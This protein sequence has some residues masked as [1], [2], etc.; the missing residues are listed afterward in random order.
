M[1]SLD[2]F[3][4][5]LEVDPDAA[6]THA[7]WG[8]LSEEMAVGLLESSG[9]LASRVRSP[10]RNAP[11]MRVVTHADG[12]CVAV[13]DLG[14][15]P[16]RDLDHEDLALHRIAPKKLRVHLCELLSLQPSRSRVTRLSGPLRLGMATLSP[17][18]TIPVILFAHADPRE[19]RT[20]LDGVQDDSTG[21]V[22]LLT[23]TS[24]RWDDSFTSAVQKNGSFLRAIVDFVEESATGEWIVTPAWDEFLAGLA[25][26]QSRN[27]RG[28]RPPKRRGQRTAHRERIF[29]ELCAE[30]HSRSSMIR[31]CRQN[32]TEPTLPRLLHYEIAK[33]AG[34]KGYDVSR[35]LKDRGGK[36]IRMLFGIATD[37]NAIL[38]WSRQQR[39]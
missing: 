28:K 20:M 10:V 26:E 39:A 29:S 33:R 11:D 14:F 21:P 17:T 35:V 16:R 13:C 3:W 19:Y 30:L 4:H 12:T 9:G 8:G 7:E 27:T 6:N 34:C 38:R 5:T 15:S 25:N 32:G 22:V 2:Q 31:A 23:P 1:G 36:I 24:E 18:R 37:A